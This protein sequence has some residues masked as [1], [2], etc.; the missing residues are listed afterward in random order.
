[1][2]WR[3]PASNMLSSF[4]SRWMIMGDPLCSRCRPSAIWMH[5]LMPCL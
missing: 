5:H 4:R 1:M 3:L 2:T